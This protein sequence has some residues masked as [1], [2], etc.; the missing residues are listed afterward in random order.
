MR[1]RGPRE[2]DAMVSAV[3]MDALAA[4]RRERDVRRFVVDR[5]DLLTELAGVATFYE[6]GSELG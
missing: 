6:P 1:I 5:G 3:V 4:G 2:L